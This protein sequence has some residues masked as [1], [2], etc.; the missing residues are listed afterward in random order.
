[1]G[2]SSEIEAFVI[3]AVAAGLVYIVKNILDR[4]NDKHNY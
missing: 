1:M 3:G 4:K 2:S